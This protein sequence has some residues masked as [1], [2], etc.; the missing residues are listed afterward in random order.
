MATAFSSRFAF[1]MENLFDWFTKDDVRRILE[2]Y[3]VKRVKASKIIEAFRIPVEDN[4]IVR[5]FPMIDTGEKCEFCGNP[6]CINLPSN[7]SIGSVGSLGELYDKLRDFAFC[8]ECGHHPSD[9]FCGCQGCRDRRRIEREA[10]EEERKRVLGEFGKEMRSGGSASVSELHDIGLLLSVFLFLSKQ[11]P[12]TG[13]TGPARNW[14]Y[15]ARSAFIMEEVLGGELSDKLSPVLFSF[16]RPD[17][18]H[19]YFSIKDGQVEYDPLD[20]VLLPRIKELAHFKSKELFARIGKSTLVEQ[21]EAVSSFWRKLHDAEAVSFYT[22]ENYATFHSE[23]AVSEDARERLHAIS[24]VLPLNKVRY[25]FWNA[26]MRALKYMATSNITLQHAKN[27]TLLIAENYLAKAK[28]EGWEI[29]V[30][31]CWRS[32]DRPLYSRLFYQYFLPM[33]QDES[34]KTIPSLGKVMEIRQGVIDGSV[35]I[36]VSLNEGKPKRSYKRRPK[37]DKSERYKRRL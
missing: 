1:C 13:G 10:A 20:A 19:N 35:E 36:G 16:F 22:T 11:K 4:R 18:K 34:V 15:F 24:S 17:M 12:K 25:L 5:L 30:S 32:S 23:Q 28:E 3:Y 27:S 9:S 37:E 7:G 2:L 29:P 26:S 8:S 31:E 14:T 6:L 21:P 33:S